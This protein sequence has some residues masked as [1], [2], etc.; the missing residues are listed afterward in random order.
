MSRKIKAKELQF[1]VSSAKRFTH[2][3]VCFICENCG[4]EVPKSSSTCRN[5]C[6]FCLCSKH[7][8]KFPGDRANPCGGLMRPVAY[9]IQKKHSVSL[10]FQCLS[11]GQI[12][13]NKALLEDSYQADPLELILNL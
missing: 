8:D 1:P 9:H 7:V 4:L 10:S 13:H 12:K 2:I 11:C 3:N 6:P 5:H